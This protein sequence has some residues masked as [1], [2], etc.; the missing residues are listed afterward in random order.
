MSTFIVA[1]IQNCAGSNVTTNLNQCDTFAREAKANGADLVLLPEYFSC[2]E[3]AGG[4]FKLDPHPEDEHPALIRFTALAAELNIWILLGSVAVTT[5]NSKIANRSILLNPEGRIAARYDKIHLFDVD[6]PGGE[7]YRESNAISPG[8]R[9]VVAET[10][11][12]GL[13]LSVCYDLRFPQLYRSL[14][15]AGSSFLA[16]PAAFARTTGEAHWHVMLRSRAIETGCYVFASCQTGCHG[17]SESF[18][19]SLIIDPWGRVVADGGTNE[20]IIYGK[21]DPTAVNATRSQIP[22]LRH[23]RPFEQPA[24]GL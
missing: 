5:V 1:C 2:L 12:G 20:G 21:I 17:D 6:L 23:D 14:A 16:V 19:H 11:W 15:K 24:S 10:P 4:S 7:S 13:G 9:A 22:A 3:V 18:G 8:D